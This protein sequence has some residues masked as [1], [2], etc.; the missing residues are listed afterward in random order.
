M[1]L[2]RGEP[3]IVN[4]LR[5]RCLQESDP[6]LHQRIHVDLDGLQGLLSGKCEQI[7][8]E[9]R[10]PVGRLA[11]QRHDAREVRFALYSLSEDFD[12]P[13]NNG[14]HVVEVMRDAAGKLTHR[15]H[16]LCL[17]KLFLGRA[18]LGDIANERD[19]AAF[20]V[21]FHVTEAH[22]N[23]DLAP[24]FAPAH[25]FNH[26][27]ERQLLTG[28]QVILDTFGFVAAQFL[29]QQHAQHLPDD[30]FLLVTKDRFH[31]GIREMDFAF[32]I[33][34]QH[35]VRRGFP[36]EAVAQFALEQFF[37]RF[38]AF[39]A[40]CGFAELTFNRGSETIEIA[41]HQVIVRACFHCRHG[42]GF[43]NA[44]GNNDQRHADGGRPHYGGKAQHQ[45][46]IGKREKRVA[47]GPER[48]QDSK[49]SEDE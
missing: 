1:R 38:A 6:F 29:G 44:A 3:Q 11:D 27:R 20:S 35:G 9:F 26:A 43:T 33:H 28:V 2:L 24:I 18:L 12:R 40:I 25:G 5:M 32:R 39:A 48:N 21:Q 45:V 47:A 8:S 41:L 30:L 23:H 16:L 13:R 19:V 15:L 22:L 14:E 31:G 4:D 36:K 37:P 7:C 10:S 49:E 42:G 17:D 46:E 34:Q